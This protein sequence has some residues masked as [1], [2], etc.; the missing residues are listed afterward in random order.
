M[1]K[2]L[3]VTFGIILAAGLRA[4]TV[5]YSLPRTVIA[6]EVDV[7]KESTFAGPYAAYAKGMLG[8][9]VPQK[10][11]SRCYI[12]EIRTYV[13]VEADP[14]A[15]YQAVSSKAVSELLTL[16]PLGLVSLGGAS[17]A[18]SA[19][20][21]F[22]PKAS[23]N[24]FSRNGVGTPYQTVKETVYQEVKTDSTFTRVPVQR[25]V[26]VEKSLEQRAQEAANIIL[27][28]REERFKITIG[29]TDATFSGE[30]LGSAI[31]ELTRMEEEYMVLFTGYTVSSDESRT[32][33]VIPEKG[34]ETYDVFRLS[35]SEG[36][37]APDAKSGKPYFMDVIPV[38]TAAPAADEAAKAGKV[39]LYYRV[40]AI[41]AVTL[42]TGTTPLARLRLPVSQLGIEEIIPIK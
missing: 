33:E 9:D 14:T 7:T 32:F 13:R 25:D 8:I 27:R 29:D 37:L 30:A 42:G 38:Q 5:T 40:P 1:K 20:W 31:A 19:S 12:R 10:D 15:R 17:A 6:V 18:E 23:G 2:A 3:L 22:A 28:A 21:T 39:V 11:A 41:C 35:D 26:V 16:S 4:Q 36:L 24:E 34:T